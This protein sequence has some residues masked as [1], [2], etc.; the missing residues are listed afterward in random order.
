MESSLPIDLAGTPILTIL[1]A[2]PLIGAILL[3]TAW[4]PDL[5]VTLVAG[6]P[7]L[8]LLALGAAAIVLPVFQKRAQVIELQ[9]QVAAAAQALAS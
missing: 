7:W 9:P 4:V 1:L 5:R 8:L 2:V 3:S 6:G